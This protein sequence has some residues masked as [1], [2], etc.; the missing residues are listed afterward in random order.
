MLKKRLEVIRKKK[1]VVLKYLKN[2]ITDLLRNGLDIN[3]YGRV[4]F[5]FIWVSAV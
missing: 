5:R 1:G 2:D 4:S 3:A